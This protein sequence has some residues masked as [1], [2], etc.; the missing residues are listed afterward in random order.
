[1]KL[2]ILFLL[3]HIQATL[4]VSFSDWLEKIQKLSESQIDLSNKNSFELFL[5]IVSLHLSG[6]GVKSDKMTKQF[7]G[8]VRTKLTPQ[9]WSGLEE[10]G[11]F[12]VMSLFLVLFRIRTDISFIVSALCESLNKM[13]NGLLW[14]VIKLSPSARRLSFYG[15]IKYEFEMKLYCVSGVGKYCEITKY[16]SY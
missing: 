12:H 5:A 6:D 8:R 15:N 7:F 3:N 16:Y 11:L 13:E 2:I 1:M 4:P 14:K 10:R 9:K